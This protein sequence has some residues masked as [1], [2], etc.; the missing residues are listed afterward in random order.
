MNIIQLMILI[1]IIIL[2]NLQNDLLYIIPS[3]NFNNI[4]ELNENYFISLHFKI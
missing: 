4:K 3:K 2:N 1:H